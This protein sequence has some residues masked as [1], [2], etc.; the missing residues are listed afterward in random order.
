MRFVRVPENQQIGEAILHV[1][2]S[3]RNNLELQSIDKVRYTISFFANEFEKRL[4]YH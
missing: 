1:N 3:P 4:S 2:V